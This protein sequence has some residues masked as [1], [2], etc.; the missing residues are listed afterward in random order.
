MEVDFVVGDSLAIEV[1]A[2][3]RVSE[4][5]LRALR[6]LA[7]EVPLMRKIVVCGDKWRRITA[8]GIEIVPVEEFFR[9]LWRDS[10]L[11]P[12]PPFRAAPDR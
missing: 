2:K 9:E 10:L 4:S 11:A 8:D 6:A 3:E 5:A 12:V 1:K 7:E